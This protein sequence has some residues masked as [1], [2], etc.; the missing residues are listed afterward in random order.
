VDILLTDLTQ[1]EF[2]PK[3]SFGESRFSGMPACRS[4]GAGRKNLKKLKMELKSVQ[5]TI[6]SEYSSYMIEAKD[7]SLHIAKAIFRSECVTSVNH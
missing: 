2:C 5:N 4:L 1:N 3:D 6:K 7:S